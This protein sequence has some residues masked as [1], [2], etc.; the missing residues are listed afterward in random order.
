MKPNFKLL[1]GIAMIVMLFLWVPFAELRAVFAELTLQVVLELILVSVALLLVSAL[2][3]SLF[4]NALAQRVP[5]RT[6]VGLY[7][8]G[9]FVNSLLPS[10]IAGDVTRSYVLGKRI[11]QHQ[12]FAATIL[13]R[14][15]GLVAMLSLALLTMWF[16]SGVTAEMQ[17][18]VVLLS[19]GLGLV[20]IVALSPRLL[21][22]LS[23]FP[24]FEPP[25][26]HLSKIQ[27]ALR[28]GQ[29]DR[30]LV[31]K[32]LALSYL[33]HCLTVL[34]TIVCARAVGWFDVPVV[35]LFVVLP[36]ILTV[37]A[38][39]LT[40]SGIGLQEGAF[41]FFLTTLG[42]TPAQAL[43][44]GLVLRAKILILAL[45]GGVYWLSMKRSPQH[46]GQ[47]TE[48]QSESETLDPVTCVQP[49]DQEQ[50]VAR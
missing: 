12:T 38:V 1:L 18:A 34:N 8:V 23:R 14:F 41:F 48:A 24:A 6:L 50:K 31:A 44:V 9:Y 5:V 7:T 29:S 25:V 33:Y 32:A 2:K 39:P 37:S 26:Q 21:Q 17:I 16:V 46:Q 13:E 43:G 22:V 40:P 4:L 49:A 30:P 11:G 45:A 20:A 47:G 28:M 35:E 15:T 19:V 3:W 42:A 10:Q 27:Q 36:L